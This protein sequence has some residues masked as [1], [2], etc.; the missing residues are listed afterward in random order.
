MRIPVAA[1]Y[2]R[3]TA[4]NLRN[5]ERTGRIVAHRHPVNRHRLFKREKL[6]RLLRRDVQPVRRRTRP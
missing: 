5:R 2:L 6:D 3:V 1:E 4:T